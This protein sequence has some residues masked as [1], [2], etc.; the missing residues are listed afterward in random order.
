MSHIGIIVNPAA[1]RDIRRLTGG[2]SVVDNHTKRRI[3]ECVLAGLTLLPD[4]PTVTLMPDNAGIAANIVKNAPKDVSVELLDMSITGSATDTRRAAERFRTEADS[5]VVLGGDGTSRDAALECGDVPLLSVSTGTNNVVPSAID[6]TVAGAAAALVATDAV[7][8]ES[9]TY[10][11]GM[12]EAQTES[13]DS[14]TG[15]AAVELSDRSFVGTRALLDPDELLGGIVSRASPSEIGLSGIAGALGPLEPS[16]PD[17]IG[18]CLADAEMSEHTVRAIVA[19]GVTT[20]VGI[21][22]YRQLS[23]GESMTIEISEGVI[24]ADGERELEITDETV[25]FRPVPDGPRLVSFEAVF[26]RA[27]RSGVLSNG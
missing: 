25:E 5:L 6:G 15:L 11:H 16:T 23:N 4:P 26:E 10:H 18:L 17:A 12:V 9:V 27:A 1:G 2:A 20:S 7:D 8:N 19:P 22:E 21:E 14:V 3:A 13:G 24:G